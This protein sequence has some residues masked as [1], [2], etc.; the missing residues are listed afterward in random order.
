MEKSKQDQV[1][2][3]DEELVVISDGNYPTRKPGRDD[4]IADELQELLRLE[5][6]RKAM[7]RHPQ[8]VGRLAPKSWGIH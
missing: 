8:R 7:R 2:I 1:I 6:D 5:K 3:R 4:E